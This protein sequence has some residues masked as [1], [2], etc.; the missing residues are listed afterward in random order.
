[1]ALGPTGEG[2][3][4]APLLGCLL[5]FAFWMVVFAH[6]SS[7]NLHVGAKIV[8]VFFWGAATLFFCGFSRRGASV[9]L[10]VIS[11]LWAVC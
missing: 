1:M 10:S 2:Q 4:H 5:L 7:L 11:S 6:P 8:G 3:E 9:V